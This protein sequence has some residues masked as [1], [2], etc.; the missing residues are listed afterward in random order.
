MFS[1][2]NIFVGFF[3]RNSLIENQTK[4]ITCHKNDTTVVINIA[5]K[6]FNE[7]S[8]SLNRHYL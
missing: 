2:E 8:E 1:F 4:I 7:S 3:A 6:A 5:L